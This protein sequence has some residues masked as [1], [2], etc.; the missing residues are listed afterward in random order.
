MRAGLRLGTRA[1]GEDGLREG[2]GRAA[3]VGWI[4][5]VPLLCST[6]VGTLNNN[7]VNVPL[8]LVVASL[9]VDIARGGLIVV[10]FPL[11]LAV[12]MPLAG[13]CADRLGRRTMLVGAV[14]A[15]SLVSVGAALA[16]SLG[17]LV[18]ARALQGLA[19]AAIL[20]C[21]MGLITDLFGEGRRGRA[22]GMWAAANGLGQAV[23]PPLGGIVASSLGWRAVFAPA[24]AIGVAAAAGTLR[25]VPKR[26][27]RPS[28][29]EWRGAALLTCGTGCVI[30]AAML[31][32]V[33]HGTSPVVIGLAVVGLLSLVALRTAGRRAPEPFVDPRLWREPSFLRSS[34][35]VFTQMFCLGATLLAVPL[36]LT[37]TG[38]IHAGEAGIIVFALPATMTLL[39]PLAGVATERVGPRRVLRTGLVVLVISECALGAVAEPGAPL[40]MLLAALVLAGLGVALVQTPA[41]AGA[42][43]SAV[44]RVGTGLGLYNSVRFAGSALGAAWITVVLASGD[45]YRLGFAVAALI[46]SGGLLGT[47]AGPDTVRPEAPA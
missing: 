47:F 23:G 8:R 15:Q 3:D 24:I 38:R 26:S 41:A 11:A 36:L 13:W 30:G 46:A 31:V 7:I 16:P 45:H 40:A 9:H 20:P 33:L 25:L 19:S 6:F 42:T 27:G 37:R 5:L 34:L 18:A 29:L 2:R 4:P 1:S 14:L 28:R 35:A 43:R 21:V 44:G 32:P 39:A 22:L 17:A 10:S 12:G